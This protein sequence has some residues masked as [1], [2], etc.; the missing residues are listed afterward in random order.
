MSFWIALWSKEELLDGNKG[1]KSNDCYGMT[2]M[3]ISREIILFCWVIWQW[4][5]LGSKNNL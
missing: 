3:I 2:G 4:I 1:S 5:G